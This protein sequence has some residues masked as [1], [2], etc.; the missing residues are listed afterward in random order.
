M[1]RSILT[2][3]TFVFVALVT[4]AQAPRSS[5]PQSYVSPVEKEARWQITEWTNPDPFAVIWSQRRAAKETPDKVRAELT[6]RLKTFPT[7]AVDA[8]LLGYYAYVDSFLPHKV[9]RSPRPELYAAQMMIQHPVNNSAEFTRL[10]FVLQSRS[11]PGRDCTSAGRRLV[12]RFPNQPGLKMHLANQLVFMKERARQAE[13]IKMLEALVTQ[14][15]TDSEFVGALADAYAMVGIANN[16]A[17]LSSK[18]KATYERFL[19][20][21][22]ISDTS[23]NLATLRL[24]AVKRKINP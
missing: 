3:L 15:P 1:I 12:A 10:R 19:K 20:L 21:P 22:G 6:K 14:F 13:G 18:A 8:Y 17:S 9:V 7:N 4:S 24:Q 23:R 16:D 11:W 5:V 2:V